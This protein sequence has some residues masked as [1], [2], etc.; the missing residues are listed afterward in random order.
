LKKQILIL[1]GAPSQEKEIIDK[2]RIKEIKAT[3]YLTL[4]TKRE[5]LPLPSFGNHKYKIAV[6]P[7][8]LNA[9]FSHQDQR[10]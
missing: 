10:Y 4:L 6:S 5:R 7:V 1:K 9:T 3:L 8:K 2:T